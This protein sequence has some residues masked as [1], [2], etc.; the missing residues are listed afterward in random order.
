MTIK[1]IDNIYTATEKDPSAFWRNINITTKTRPEALSAMFTALQ[2]PHFLVPK[3]NTR[4][5]HC[6]ACDYQ[7]T[8]D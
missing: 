4:E 7:I 6:V 8:E 5:M 3:Y 2:C 1:K